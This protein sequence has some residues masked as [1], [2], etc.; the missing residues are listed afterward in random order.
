MAA[1]MAKAKGTRRAPMTSAR[2]KINA[3]PEKDALPCQ[4]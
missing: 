2:L 1:V 4:Q 3:F